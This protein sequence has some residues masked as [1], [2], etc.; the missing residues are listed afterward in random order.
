MS[1]SEVLEHAP[2]GGRPL[3]VIGGV[4]D[5]RVIGVIGLLTL[6]ALSGCQ[7]SPEETTL[8]CA[9]LPRP[10]SRDVITL[11]P[12]FSG[13]D[14]FGGVDLLRSPSDGRWYLPTQ[15][16][17]IYVFDDREDATPSVFA[18]LSG[19]IVEGGEAGL[20]GMAF[21]PDYAANGEVFLSYTA[22]GG[23]AFVSRISRL[24]SDD[25][26]TLDLASESVVLEVEQPYTNHNGGDIGFGPDGYLY[27]GLGDGGS[28]GD[29]M[30][31][32]QNVDTLLGAMLRIDVDGGGVEPYGI[33]ADNP[34]AAGG[35]SPEI[36]AWG[37]RNPWRWSF[38][39]ETGDLWVGDVGQ[40]V[41]EEVNQVELGQNYGWNVR[42]ADEC[43]DAETCASA[44]LVDPVAQYRNT[45]SAS[46]IGGYVYRGASLPALSGR[47]VYSDYYLGT[48]WGVDPAG[49][50]MVL[51]DASG[52]GIS[53]FAE[54]EDGELYAL[55]YQGGIF[56]LRA[57]EPEP[58]GQEHLPTLLS[59][60]G[61]VDV[62]GPD[63]GETPAAGALIPYTINVPFWSDG[64]DKGRMMALPEG[65]MITVGEDGDWDL[66]PGSVLVKS[67]HL[68]ERP[69]ETRLFVRHADGAW[70]G[71][72]YRWRDDGSDAELLAE[73][74]TAEIAGQTWNF[75]SRGECLFCHTAA[76]G[77][78]LGLETAQLDLDVEVD[79]AA[80][81]QLDHL[82][83]LGVLAVRPEGAGA[84]YPSTSGE[85]ALE[86]RARAY[87]HSNC[88]HCHRPNAPGGRSSIDLL[89]TT[90]LAEAKI[91]DVLP[92][93]GDLGISD[94]RLIAPGDPTRS[95]LPTR[96]RS[97][98]AARMPEVGS[99]AVDD[100]GVALIEAWI[101]ELD[102][103]P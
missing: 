13:V 80:K 77:R 3:G 91:C 8:R 99:L 50:V 42:E 81:N 82:V 74:A 67:F 43:F 90:P 5:I 7:A 1:G 65:A 33:P 78:S 93:S 60:T 101:A 69:V 21:H 96:M 26:S 31:N 88:S 11:E 32:G 10:P 54:D 89:Y 85:G 66:P 14:V 63:E 79:G 97:T 61:C 46:V 41:W 95:L 71:Y 86:A 84:P 9:E 25:G 39:R 4:G 2:E 38:D 27:I 52:R 56:R 75:P 62:Q 45:Q 59:K 44:G 68:G 18:D 102:V 24:H 87:L 98:S 48:I 64:A 23:G 94:A 19:A 36:Y 6:G 100:G 83:D 76:A 29:P 20:L 22:P 17:V 72:S 35:G 70:A 15:G 73:G 37:M 51:S 12:V 53:S 28:S 30:G 58:E 103:C 40:H 55:R 16:G 92:R 47:F 57:A 34:F 49:D